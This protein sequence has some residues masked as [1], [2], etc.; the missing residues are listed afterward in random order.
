MTV[1]STPMASPFQADFDAL[2]AT[3]GAREP[4]AVTRLRRLAAARFAEVGYP[5]TKLEEWR[6]TN[7]AP[8]AR[9]AFR[10]ATGAVP[11]D[12]ESLLAPHRIPGAIELVFAGGRLAPVLSRLDGVPSGVVLDSLSALLAA[13]NPE[14]TAALG[15]RADFVDHPFVA[16]NTALFEDGAALVLPR[17]VALERPV[18]LLF[19]GGNEA[20]AATAAFPR[21]VLV[22]GERSEAPVVET[23]VGREGESYLTC[24]V[25]ELL[26]GPAAAIDHYK[27]QREGLEAFHLATFAVE[28][29]RDTR[30]SSHSISLGGAIV[31]HD[32]RALLDGEGGEANLNGLYMVRGRQLA[33]THMRVDHAKPHCASH[34]LYKGILNERARAVFNGRIFVHPHAQKTDAKQTNRNL[35]LSKDA[36][37]NTNP[38]LEIFADDVRCTH[39]STVGQLDADA[40]FYLRS[41]G[42]GEEAARSIL[43]YAFASDIVERIR[44]ETVRQALRESLLSWIPHGE[45]VRDAT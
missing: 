6:F 4:E 44:V 24:A 8:V 29:G 37:V 22:A 36:L 5:T 41:R 33:D 15:R 23:Y 34:E 12:A 11:A 10:R 3:A 13:G 19:L 45:V 2:R 43:T 39:G 30:V 20:G 26:A 21:I 32:V 28:T 16:L 38:Q 40:V 27:V 42:I 1:T 9:T 25:T 18:H 17:G 31:R 7:V 14:V 35:L